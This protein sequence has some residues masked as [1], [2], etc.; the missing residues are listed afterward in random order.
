MDDR[1]TPTKPGAAA[2]G[3]A[4]PSAAAGLR[5][6]GEAPRL[7]GADVRLRPAWEALARQEVSVVSFDVFDTLLWR[8]VPEPRDA[9]ALLGAELDGEGLLAPGTPAAVF[10][11][12]REKAEKRARRGR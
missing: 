1:S 5:P 3:L 12:L 6:R 8:K 4:D 10:A 11:S 7:Q 2:P 9:F